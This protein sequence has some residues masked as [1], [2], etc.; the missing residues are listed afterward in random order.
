MLV[1][2]SMD[3]NQDPSGSDLWD[4]VRSLKVEVDGTVGGHVEVVGEC[5]PPSATV[6]FSKGSNISEALDFWCCVGDVV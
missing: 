2:S 4:A 5:I 1:G 3:T 6:G